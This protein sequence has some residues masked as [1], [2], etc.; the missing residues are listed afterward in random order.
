MKIDYA[1]IKKAG[2]GQKEFAE[3]LGVSRVTVSNWVNN[4]TSPSKHLESKVRNTVTLLTAANRL[5]LLPGDIPNM[6]SSNVEERKKYIH[7]KLADAAKKLRAKKRV[8]K[9]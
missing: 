7:D 9:A 4:K 6:H 1:I 3:L 8:K 2:L 5:K